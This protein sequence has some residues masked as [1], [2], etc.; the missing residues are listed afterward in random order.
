MSKSLKQFI[1]PHGVFP[2]KIGK[3]VVSSDI[4]NSVL[5]FFLLFISL[6]II[7]TLVMSSLGMDTLSA[8]ASVTACIGNIGPGLGS[9]GPMDNYS[10]IPYFGKWFLIFLMFVGR[11][12]VYTIVLLLVPEFWRK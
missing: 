5:S 2:I 8:L 4:M 9:V 12:E 3:Q 7:G 1:H 6:V 11:L 10:N